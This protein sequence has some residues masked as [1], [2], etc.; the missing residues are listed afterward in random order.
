MGGGRTHQNNNL[1]LQKV[2]SFREFVENVKSINKE[3]K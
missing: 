2:K 3:F 1:N